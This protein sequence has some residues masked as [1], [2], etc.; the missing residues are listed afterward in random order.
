LLNSEQIPSFVIYTS[1]PE[2][3]QEETE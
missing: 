2:N 3:F 1:K